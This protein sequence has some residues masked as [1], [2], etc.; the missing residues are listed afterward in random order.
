M[1][2]TAQIQSGLKE[3]PL[4]LVSFRKTKFIKKKNDI[5]WDTKQQFNTNEH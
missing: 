3:Y 5:R 2:T 4:N 1:T